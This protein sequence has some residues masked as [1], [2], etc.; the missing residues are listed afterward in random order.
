MMITSKIRRPLGTMIVYGFPK[1]AIDVDLAVAGRLGAEVV[2]VLPDWRAFPAPILL[3]KMV[4][5][6]GLKIQSAHGC[7]G[8]QSI[9]ASRVDLGSTDHRAW[10]E[11]VDD[12]RRCVDWLRDAGGTCL[13]VHPG[14]LSEPADASSRREALKRGLSLLADHAAGMGVTICVE[15]MPPGVFPGSRIIDLREVV[16]EIDRCEVALA[17]DTGHA[18][19]SASASSETLAAGPRLRTTHVHDND[20]R[21]DVHLPPGSGT[22]DWGEWVES[23]DAI[24]YRGP[25]M[26]ECIKH[27]RERPES[28]T[29]EFL[30][31]LRR[32]CGLGRS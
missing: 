25:I 10:S 21:Q 18:N 8:G 6:R 5:D 14:G 20:G 23:L 3:R 24:D 27:L 31:G 22:I 17:L 30:E 16:D 12:L 9:R 1:A 11:S 13:V 2:E 32:M 15:N 29:G 26:L 4:E 7:W 19:I 28:L